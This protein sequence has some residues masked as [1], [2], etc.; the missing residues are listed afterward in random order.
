MRKIAFSLFALA[1]GL[2]PLTPGWPP[3]ATGHAE[4]I[5]PGVADPNLSHAS[6]VGVNVKSE[7]GA[8]GDNSTD[9]TAAFQAAIVAL[10]G[11]GGG[12]LQIPPGHYCIKS[13]P[14]NIES[15]GI[16]ISGVNQ[17][18][19]LL[20]ACS[21]DVK[22][23]TS[24]GFGTVIRD[25]GIAG[26]RTPGTTKP[27]IELNSGCT[28]C[29]VWRT[30]ITA[31]QYGIKAISADFVIGFTKVT[32]AYGS[33]LVLVQNGGGYIIRAKLDQSYPLAP[34]PGASLTNWQ[35]NT[36]YA[37][38]ALVIIN[39]H[40]LEAVAGGTSGAV[41][42][43]T[44]P[45]NTDA[46]DGTVSWQ[47]VGASI[48]Y[49]IQL[50]TGAVPMYISDTD[51][52]G[53]YTAALGMTNSL[54]GAAPQSVFLT[55]STIDQT[56]SYGVRGATG[57]GLSVKDTQI[58]NCVLSG[59][60]GITLER[61]YE[62]DTHIEGNF[63]MAMPQGIALNAGSAG[64]TLIIGNTIG[65]SYNAILVGAGVSNFTVVGNNLGTSPNWGKNGNGL[66]ILPGPSDH[67]R[68]IGNDFTGSNLIDRGTGSHK[69]VQDVNG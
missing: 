6:G 3:A 52:T 37:R 26:S 46:T 33:A 42:P 43:S 36:V 7:F 45:Y 69:T 39:G 64:G 51:M 63:L 31:G 68:M 48:Y 21:A 56:L 40:I 1:L 24:T 44:P 28:E 59:C 67:Y 61:D 12:E 66:N 27:A 57:S 54:G 60:N 35:A 11:S 17:R 2:M 22:I 5:L 34:D 47:L 38:K 16:T 55:H 32:Q 15:N 8:K 10:A 53:P 20:D 41:A 9:D 62:G 4:T 50:D 65:G 49:A 58:S 19:V 13:G 14:I 25:V 18:A 23:I 30:F 29:Y